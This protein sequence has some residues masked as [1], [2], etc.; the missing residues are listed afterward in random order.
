MSDSNFE[1]KSSYQIVALNYILNVVNNRTHIENQK[2]KYEGLI[3][4]AEQAAIYSYVSH[5]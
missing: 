5:A 1:L 4:L 2:T 3:Q